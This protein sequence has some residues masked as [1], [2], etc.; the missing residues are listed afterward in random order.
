L[1]ICCRTS[2]SRIFFLLIWR[3]HHYRWRA[4]K[5]RSMLGAQ[6]LWAGRDLYRAIPAVTRDLGFSDLI[7]RTAPFSQ[8]LKDYKDMWRI[9]SNPDPYG[10]PISHLLRHTRGCWGSI[11][12]RILMGDE[13]WG[14][15]RTL[16]LWHL[17]IQ[18]YIISFVFFSTPMFQ[19]TVFI[20]KWFAEN[21]RLART[22]SIPLY[23]NFLQV[24]YLHICWLR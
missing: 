4:A 10:S 9:Y 2:R 3:S 13:L 19:Y 18:L 16:C 8:L 7:R 22:V 17:K 23:G 15:M 12:T 5:Y 14:K 21:L 1:I 20:N 6:G 24:W 11:L